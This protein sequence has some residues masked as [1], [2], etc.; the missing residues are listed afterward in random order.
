MRYSK[1]I[2]GNTVVLFVC[3]LWMDCA[4]GAGGH[5][6]V[7]EKKLLYFPF[8]SKGKVSTH[9]KDLKYNYE[10]CVYKKI[11]INQV[12]TRSGQ[13]DCMFIGNEK[14]CFHFAIYY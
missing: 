6:L 14:D 7:D 3:I 10:S 5:P 9:T 8:L 12:R 2:T 11:Q 4:K 1:G 13:Y